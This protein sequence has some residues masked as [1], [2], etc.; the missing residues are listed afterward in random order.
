[1]ETV[2][3]KQLRFESLYS[4]GVVADLEG[5]QIT[6][7][8][9]GVLSDNVFCACRSKYRNMAFHH[10]L[11]IRGLNPMKKY[12]LWLSYLQVFVIFDKFWLLQVVRH[13]AKRSYVG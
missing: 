7:D 10:Q 1:M 9:G 8:A 4:K 11:Y 3:H 2:S 12:L 13:Q 6:L 5:G